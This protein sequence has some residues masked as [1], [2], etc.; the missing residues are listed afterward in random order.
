MFSLFILFE[1]DILGT[2]EII[3]D[4]NDE[5]IEMFKTFLKYEIEPRKLKE[6]CNDNKRIIDCHIAYLLNL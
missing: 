2:D 1:N 5:N 3:P 6:I 4:C